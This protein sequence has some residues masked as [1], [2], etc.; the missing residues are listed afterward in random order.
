MTSAEQSG[1]LPLTEQVLERLGPPRWL[2]ILFWAAIPVLAPGILSAVLAIQGDLSRVT[3]VPGLL[4]P[5]VVIGGVVV[6]CLW[7][8]GRLTRQARALEPDL[9]RLT[10]TEHPL[11]ALPGISPL[12]PPVV[13]TVIIETVNTVETS[14]SY[15]AA[16]AL[17]V[18]PLLTLSLLP[19]MTFVW[20]Y[21][22]LLLGLDRLG[23]ARLTL[24]LFPQD[25][26]LGLGPVGALAFTGFV[27][28]WAVVV[29]I[30]IGNQNPST[31]AVS[32]GIVAVLVGLFFLSMWRLHG[33]MSAAKARYIA[34]TRALF[35]QAYEPMRQAG[36]LKTLQSQAPLLG[37]AQAL[38]ERAQRILEWPIDEQMVGRVAIILT[39]IV[40]GLILRFIQIAANL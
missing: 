26:S 33:Q 20:T 5:Q 12:V 25:R 34:Q 18:L 38:E 35:A 29:P 14:R 31:F 3:S 1:R 24:D 22:Q 32:V 13:L 40:T 39:G 17:A 36:T 23:R 19:I 27:I 2:W 8:V 16:A 6:V 9:V 4:I 15:G 10:P 21:L 37:P 7:G 11:D 28:V 30:L